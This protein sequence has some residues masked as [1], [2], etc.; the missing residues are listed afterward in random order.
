VPSIQQFT[1]ALLS[2]KD[3]LVE[4]DRLGVSVVTDPPLAGALGLAEYQRLV[5]DPDASARDAAL[6]H[7]D[8][9][10]FEA[11]GGVVESMGRLA[12]A[13]CR[14]P[15]PKLSDPAGA[16]AR[17]LTVQN[18]VARL[19]RTDAA[20]SVYVG[21]VVEYE[22]LADERTGGLVEVWVNP[23]TRS[24]AHWADGLLDSAALADA[25][26]PDGL[27]A[28]AA[29]AWTL[30]A[31]TA[32]ALVLDR[33]REFRESLIRR[34]DRDLRRLREYYQAIDGE[35]RRKITRAA[36]GGGCDLEAERRRLEATA[37]SFRARATDLVERSRLRLRLTPLAALA[38]MLPMY[39][40]H[41]ELKRRTATAS[42][43][44]S[45]NPIDRAIE[46]R[47]CDGCA[48]ATLV[49]ALCD[50]RV[51]YLCSTCLAPCPSC[52]KPFC[53]ACHGRCPRRHE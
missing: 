37:R 47:C 17:A 48:R 11:M 1:L 24:I 27:A 25:Q 6:V 26:A 10:V 15:S 16:L 45:W 18:G 33:T 41:V 43:L 7:Y 31:P 29:Q 23:V 53:R 4:P 19:Q 20:V 40:L 32:S 2:Y 38:C 9:P 28:T 42:V 14:V 36:A 39:Q 51:H 13:A 8:S 44:F 35:I 50:E 22:L 46:P 34:R 49:A 21:F 30:A 12:F 3:A 5:F 52:G